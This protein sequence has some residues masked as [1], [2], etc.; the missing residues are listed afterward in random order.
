MGLTPPVST[1]WITDS[2]ASFHTTPDAGIL[3]CPT[4]TSLLSFF[5]HGW[6]WVFL[7]P[8]WVLLL[9]LSVFSMFLLLLR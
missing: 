8:P 6:R 7:S 5:H 9:V 2:G 3:F 1:E 4:P